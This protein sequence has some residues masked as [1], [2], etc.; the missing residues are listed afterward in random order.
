MSYMSSLPSDAIAPTYDELTQQ[1]AEARRLIQHYEQQANTSVLGLEES[2][3]SDLFRLHSAPMLLIDAESGRIVDA[4]ISAC[5]FYG[6]SYNEFLEK[7]VEDINT[8]DK[9]AIQEKQKKALLRDQNYFQFSHRLKNGNI[10]NV[11]VYS[12]PI[13]YKSR[14]IL[15]S[16]IHDITDRCIAEKSL[17]SN[18]NLLEL[19]F[20]QSLDGI[21]FMMLDEPIEWNEQSD[22]DKLLDYIFENQR[23]TKINEAMLDQYGATADAFIGLTPKDFYAHDIAYGRQVWRDFFD[24][25]RLHIDTVERRFDGS[26]MIVLGDYICIYDEQQRI[27]GHFG[28]QR[29]ATAERHAQEQL[30]NGLQNFESLFDSIDYYLNILDL[31][32]N[33]IYCNKT[34]LNK[35]EYTMEELVGKHALMLRPASRAAEAATILAEMLNGT[36]NYCPI[37]LQTKSGDL[38]PVESYVTRGIWNNKTTLFCISKDISA[39]RNSEEKFAKT[40][41]LNPAIAGLSLLE[42]GIYV[43]VN[44]SFY[45][46]LEFSPDE[47]IGSRAIDILKIDV[48]TR[49]KII[50][51]I[52]ENGNIRNEE[53]IIHTKSGKPL[54]V[55]LS[56]EIIEINGIRY[57]YTIVTDI[58][59]LKQAQN[60]LMETE[61]RLQ[62]AL[63]GANEGIWDWNIETGKVLYNESWASMLGYQ[64]AEI[65]PT[66]T[67]WDLL[68]HPDDRERVYEALQQHFAGESEA[69]K[70]EH[71][72][73]TKSGQWKWILDH[74]QV[75]SRAADGRPLR[76]MG[77]HVDI[78]DLKR[79]QENL[80]R[81]NAELRETNAT[82]DKLFSIIGHDLR[83]P[84]GSIKTLLELILSKIDLSD[85]PQLA[86]MLQAL[87]KTSSTTFELLENLLQWSKTQRKDISFSPEPIHLVDIVVECTET[88]GE[89]IRNKQIKLINVIDDSIFVFSDRNMLMIIL[90][91]LLSNAVKFTPDS[92]HIFIDYQVVD[93]IVTISVRDEGIGISAAKLE[94]IFSIQHL[95]T[96]GTAGE[97]GS[98]LGLVLCQEFVEKQGGKIWAES[99]PGQGSTFSFTLPLWDGQAIVH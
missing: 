76:A 51:K 20:T 49:N 24:N 41:H 18:A 8:L 89:A 64:L 5:N 44:Q 82:K 11:E 85:N 3:F 48:D 78:D 10:K 12:S 28:I 47:V 97:K 60:A 69:Y 95:S 98:G 21:F 6:Y 59:E 34:L 81:L 19:F 4:N 45:K 57:N 36:R 15:F 50:N 72:L 2:G 77:T 38:I 54:N 84:I 17:K 80:I 26:E 67:S 88:L 58:T 79:A 87:K 93:K 9:K 16:I 13:I 22:K 35:L 7:K 29:D 1:L 30:K 32:G 73:Q 92:N 31:N 23:V 39:I 94:N 75:V 71:R 70:T 46:K 65:E 74:G 42:T 14:N 43:E 25:G 96:S 66:L 91:N 40:F 86:Q 90:R 33:I 27:V 61:L 53:A 68:V 99:E 63:K 52:M 83:G 62:F 55:L 56:A 37:P